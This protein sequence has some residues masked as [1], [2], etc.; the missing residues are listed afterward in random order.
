MNLPMILGLVVLSVLAGM[1]VSIIGYYTPLILASSILMSIGAGLL[2]TLHADS[3][4][5]HWIGYQLL[6][7]IGAG[8]GMQLPLVAVQTA[9][10][11][12]D[13]PIATAIL[14][15]S[16]TLGGS[17]FVQAAQN[18]F[19]NELIMGLRDVG[20]DADAVLT[21]GATELRRLVPKDIVPQ[22]IAAYNEA[23]T[24]TWNISVAMAAASVLPA[25]F[26]PWKSVKGKK[27]EAHAG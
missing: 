8:L 10:A 23:L 25:V 9:L 26:I 14:M 3:G 24:S 18:I 17:V 11:E 13:V 5:S 19:S 16:Q 20:V 21:V 4:A 2:T 27:I 7:G 12:R 15:F 22:V 6:Y 1:A